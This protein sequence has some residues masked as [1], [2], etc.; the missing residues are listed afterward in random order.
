MYLINYEYKKP[1]WEN[2]RAEIKAKFYA[3][4]LEL[5]DTP[6]KFWR[7]GDV[8]YIRT[9]PD[10]YRHGTLYK[11]EGKNIF[12]KRADYHRENWKLL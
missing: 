4:F 2:Q 1:K 10:E 12:Y 3:N 6:F 5:S 11:Y 8:Y 9:H 7:K